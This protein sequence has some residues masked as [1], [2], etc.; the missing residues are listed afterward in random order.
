MCSACAVNLL[1]IFVLV[2]MKEVWETDST[3]YSSVENTRW[4]SV[5][6]VCLSTAYRAMEIMIRSAEHV[7]LK[8]LRRCHAEIS[9]HARFVL[10][11]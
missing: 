3:W 9:R 6:A 1:W 10:S 4:P 7:I 8:G 2:S 11:G 5:I